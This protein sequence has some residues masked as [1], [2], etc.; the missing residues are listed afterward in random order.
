MSK[1]KRC[2]CGE[3]P[4]SLSVCDAGQGGKRAYVYGDC[5][6]TW[7]IEFRTQYSDIDS[8]ECMEL[9]IEAWNEALR[10][11]VLS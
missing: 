4:T 11:K 3:V 6:N 9:G 10:A 8:K 2:P 5:C 7:E 1:L